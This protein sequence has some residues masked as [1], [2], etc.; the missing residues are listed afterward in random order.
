MLG[1]GGWEQWIHYGM[2]SSEL[3]TSFIIQQ[4]HMASNRPQD[5]LVGWKIH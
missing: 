3:Q 5:D 2:E 1:G 4:Q